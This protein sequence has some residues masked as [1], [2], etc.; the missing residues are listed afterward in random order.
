MKRKI[1]LNDPSQ[2]AEALNEHFNDTMIHF[3]KSP[4]NV[5]LPCI[6]VRLKPNKWLY[7]DTFCTTSE[8]KEELLKALKGLGIDKPEFNNTK[9]AFWWQNK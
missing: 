7:E 1:D 2:V 9:S 8:F 4:N 5:V 3:V 6:N